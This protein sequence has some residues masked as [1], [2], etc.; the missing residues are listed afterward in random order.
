MAPLGETGIGM[1]NLVPTEDGIWPNPQMLPSVHD[2]F[3]YA[4]LKKN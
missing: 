4:L 2:G 1:M 3:F